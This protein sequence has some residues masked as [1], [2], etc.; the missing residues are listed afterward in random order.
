[1]AEETITVRIPRKDENG[2]QTG[3][4][5]ATISRE[6]YDAQKAL[7]ADKRHPN[8]KEMDS[9]KTSG[10]KTAEA[11]TTSTSKKTSTNK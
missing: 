3:Y 5:E 11:E 7:S 1:M 10:T 6:L 4:R 2:K 8:Y 9:W